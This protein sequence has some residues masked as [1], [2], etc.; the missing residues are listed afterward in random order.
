[1]NYFCDIHRSGIQWIKNCW[2]HNWRKGHWTWGIRGATWIL[3]SI[4]LTPHINFV[5]WL[6][7]ILID[8][9][10]HYKMFGK[11][12]DLVSLIKLQVKDEKIIRHEDWYVE[13]ERK[14]KTFMCVVLFVEG[15]NWLYAGG[16]RIHWRIER[17]WNFLFL[18]GLLKPPD[19][20]TCFSHICSWGLERIPPPL[21]F[22]LPRF[23]L[24][25]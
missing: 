16:I 18:D 13:I 24:C 7:Q 2:V 20:A 3:V 15:R 8:N 21:S 14:S 1:M 10:Q 6:L 19:G 17:L 22:S 4:F 23:K 11:D 12:V 25:M 5:Y 9:K